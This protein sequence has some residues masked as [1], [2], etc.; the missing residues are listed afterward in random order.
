[1]ARVKNGCELFSHARCNDVLFLSYD[2]PGEVDNS[3]LDNIAILNA[4]ME[5]IMPIWMFVPN[6]STVYRYPDKQYWNEAERRYGAPNLLRMTQLAL[7]DRMIDLFPANGTHVST[8]GYLMMG[9]EMLKA[10]QKAEP[11]QQLR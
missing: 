4:R 11:S 6:K 2:L 8:S 9:E 10:L 1:M 5:G 7:D 3:A